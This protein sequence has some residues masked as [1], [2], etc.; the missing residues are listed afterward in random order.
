MPWVIQTDVCSTFEHLEKHI[1]PSFKQSPDPFFVI[2][3][4]GL[5]TR[6]SRHLRIGLVGDNIQSC[7]KLVLGHH[8]H[9]VWPY[10]SLSKE[11]KVQSA[12]NEGRASKMQPLQKTMSA[13]F[14]MI[15]F[16]AK[17]GTLVIDFQSSRSY[18]DYIFQVYTAG[19][20][21]E[22]YIQE[23]S[24]NEKS[25]RALSPIGDTYKGRPGR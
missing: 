18:R 24:L 6:G 14:T 5:K 10:L 17:A 3:V 8:Y 19:M 1:P 16:F 12:E 13:S 2:V 4:Q 20:A 9:V 7:K 15:F 25:Q 11:T 22:M 21:T 23:Q